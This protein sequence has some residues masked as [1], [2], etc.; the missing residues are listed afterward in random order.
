M[1][2]DWRQWYLSVSLAQLSASLI[3][4]MLIGIPSAIVTE[5]CRVSR[6]VNHAA[7]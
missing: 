5:H 6:H 2:C 1:S 4:K 7:A 3:V